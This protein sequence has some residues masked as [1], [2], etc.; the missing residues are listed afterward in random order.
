M[1]RMSVTSLQ[2]TREAGGTAVRSRVLSA[3]PAPPRPLSPPRIFAYVDAV[4]RHG[5]IRKAADA[6]HIVSSALNRRILDLEEELGS[7]LF[8]RLPRGV[9]PT[10]AGEIFIDYVRG[11]MRELEHVS[12]QIDGLRGLL[13]GRV[14]IAVA[15]SVTGHML[16]TAIARF[17]QR[18]PNVAFHVWMDGPRALLDL[19]TADEA[20]LILT[21]DPPERADVTTIASVHQPFCALVAP[22]HPLACRATLEL[23]DCM[24]YRIAVPDRTL[25]ARTLLDLALQREPF[26]FEP[27]LVSNS[28]EMTKTFARQNLGVCF[29]FRIAGTA[30]PSGM[31]E[32]PLTDPPFERGRLLL[33]VRRNRVLPVAAGAF[34]SLLE[35]V[36]D[37]L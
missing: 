30:D 1:R 22:D 21:H 33:A 6:L 3:R 25:A 8:E 19:L 7:Q 29:Q 23:R 20:D 34:A 37:S 24:Q 2:V 35:E 9:R 11:S 17:Q 4:A 18:H 12:A 36:F 26:R 15:E 28:V 5:S 13:K 10:E 14:R 16:P 31:I 27:A 32:I